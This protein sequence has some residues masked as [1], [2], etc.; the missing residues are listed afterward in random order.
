FRSEL[1]LSSSTP[2]TPAESAVDES[3]LRRALEG[4]DLNALR[5]ALFQ[6][7]R[8]ES[9][10]TMELEPVP[11][12]GGSTFNL[13]VT[14]GARDTLTAKLLDFILRGP[15]D[16]VEA[17]PSDA[18][19]RTLMESHA[20]RPLTDRE[21]AYR[22]DTAAFDEFPRAAHWPT[23]APALPTGF[24]VA[25]IGAG[26]CGI[27]L[28]VQLG[29]LGI[30]YVI[31]ERRSRLG[32]T[33][34]INDYPDVRVDIAS[35]IY[36]F[37]F[38]K[39]YPW[40]EYF[41]RGP[42]VRAYLDH[43]ARTHGV[44]E[45]MEFGCDV[46]AADFDESTGC[47]RLTI[48]RE[49][50]VEQR[51]ATVLV[52]ATG[53]FG[54]PRPLQAPG[55]DDFAGEIVHTTQ[56][57]EHDLIDDRDVAI[58]GNGST[59][60]QLLRPVRERARTVTVF[61]RTPQWIAPNENYG[62]PIPA[63]TRW[64]LEH[65]PYYWNWQAYSAN[66]MRLGIQ[67]AQEVDP[68]WQAQGGA[69][70]PQNDALRASLTA[71]VTSIVGSRPDLVAKLIPD[72]AP[73]ARRLIV[74]NGWYASLLEPNVELVTEPIDRLTARGVRTS[75]GADRPFDVII[76][77]TGFSVSKYLWPIRIRGRADAELQEQWQSP[78]SGGPRAYLG[79]TVPDF[80]NF[81]IMFGPNSQNRAGGLVMWMETWAKYIS[82]AVIALLRSGE[83]SLSVR[84][85]VFLDYN[86]RMDADTDGLI[87]YD[88]GSMHGNYYLNEFG[89][90]QVSM[91]W[92]VEDAYAHFAEFRP[93]DYEFG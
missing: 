18:E 52:A 59:G 89:R 91:P 45:R 19:L 43:V 82:E 67:G 39:R 88:P 49:G 7:T 68:S 93:E 58:I 50:R 73:L 57:S 63:E 47:W 20:G 71:Y 54:T 51:T 9:L 56:L 3:F 72:H 25:I 61:Q 74:D 64:L 4:A 75:D 66:A 37:S 14:G 85:D 15:E 16:V 36:Q 92:R 8:D 79:M 13:A 28:G 35:F 76:S 6:A 1:M 80:P 83:R 48:S 46:R 38:E 12:N 5:I 17:A 55:V 81:F 42:E 70:S 34:D 32:G 31:Y 26:F 11:V 62:A 86:E 69:I 41:A 60:V 65:M 84:H 24:Q 44:I 78:G 87:W 77:A 90:Q 53:I 10:L 2:E 40:S 33:W 23:P 21:F 22:R 27:A 30:P 29:R